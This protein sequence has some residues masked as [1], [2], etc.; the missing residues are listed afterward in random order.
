MTNLLGY[1]R[2]LTI[3]VTDSESLMMIVRPAI[4]ADACRAERWDESSA[5]AFGP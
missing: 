4:V 5:A 2:C 3:L 1:A